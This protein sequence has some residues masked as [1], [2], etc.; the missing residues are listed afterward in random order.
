MVEFAPLSVPLERRLQTFAVLQLIFS[1]LALYLVCY[2][3]FIGLLF[4][5]FWMIS[6]LYAIWWYLDRATPR[7]GGRQSALLRGATIWKYVKDYFPISLVKTAELDPSRNYLAGFHPHG[8][9]ATG[10]FAN[11]CTEGTGFSSV[12]PGIR[13]HL[14]LMYCCFWV[15]V[16]RDYAMST[17]L[18]SSDEE[19]AVQILSRKRGGNLLSIVVGGVQES[20][21]A[22]P[23]AY[24]LVLRNRK[25]FIRLALTHGADLVPIFSF[26]E[27]D[28]YDQVEN[29]PGTWLRWF[30]DRLHKSTKCSIPLF[31]GRGVF[32]YSFGLMPYRRPITTVVGKPIEVQK[33]PHPSQEEVDRLHQRYIKELE[34][35]FEAHK[36]KYNV[37]KDQHLEI[38]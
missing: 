2:I 4:T 38:C 7:R 22:R 27:N 1:Y 29:S 14:M 23:G 12:F 24:K 5:R 6:I 13:S 26:G 18:V 8:V 30:Q 15:P 16:F 19:S 32:Q 10:A 28:I 21:N 3:V 9:L 33:T 31:Y 37:P 34:N 11:L 20:L 36:L 25:G 35:L 17:G